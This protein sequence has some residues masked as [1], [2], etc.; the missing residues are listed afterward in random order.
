M[1]RWR[2]YRPK[3]ADA[4][5]APPPADWGLS[6]ALST[7]PA[8]PAQP[9]AFPAQP[10]A[11][12]LRKESAKSKAED[13]FAFQLKS[14][15]LTGFVRQHK[16]AANRKWTLDFAFVDARVAIEIQGF[17]PGGHGGAHQSPERLH[18]QYEKHSALAIYGWRLLE[19]STRQVEDGSLLKW[20]EAA[21]GRLT[22]APGQL[23]AAPGD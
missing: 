22:D 10:A 2:D 11:V 19:G 4:G 17:G 15:G 21:L 3:G 8:A 20:T 12:A 7:S 18:A 23:P 5:S 1:S 13:L 16:F 6:A 9:A 14:I